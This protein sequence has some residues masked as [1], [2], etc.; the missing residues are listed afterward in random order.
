MDDIKK[1][2]VIFSFIL[3]IVFAI[4]KL[5]EALVDLV[6]YVEKPGD[7]SLFR[8]NVYEH[9]SEWLEKTINPITDTSKRDVHAY[10]RRVKWI[11]EYTTGLP[12]VLNSDSTTE[13]TCEMQ[14]ESPFPECYDYEY[15]YC[16]TNPYLSQ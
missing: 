3:I 8:T 11:D 14:N 12:S 13:I 6:S 2:L 1:T 15:D 16:T 9:N 4:F 10:T 5:Q 7:C